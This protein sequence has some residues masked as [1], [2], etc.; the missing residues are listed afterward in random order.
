MTKQVP[1]NNSSQQI[2]ELQDQLRG[3]QIFGRYRGTYNYTA[4][5]AVGEILGKSESPT[6]FLRQWDSFAGDMR[7]LGNMM[8]VLKRDDKTEALTA[9]QQALIDPTYTFPGET[10][11]LDKTVPVTLVMFN[12]KATLSMLLWITQGHW[13]DLGKFMDDEWD[14][15]GESRRHLTV[16]LFENFP[17]LP[18]AIRA[19]CESINYMGWDLLYAYQVDVLR[20]VEIPKDFHSMYLAFGQ[21]ND[22]IELERSRYSAKT[23]T[24]APDT[25]EVNCVGHF[26]FW[27]EGDQAAVLSRFTRE[28][29]EKM[30]TWQFHVHPDLIR[31]KDPRYLTVGLHIEAMHEEF[32]HHYGSRASAG[33]SHG[34]GGII[35]P[36]DD[37]QK[38][39]N[40]S[41][42]TELVLRTVDGDW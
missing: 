16:P 40:A 21:Y 1:E 36:P 20:G 32:Q 30:A 38:H 17:S 13:M 2:A 24:V 23:T 22:H 11:P 39:W 4:M 9:F 18:R 7:V 6:E 3:H 10:I 8:A 37:Y 41:N 12:P 42:K 25:Q 29:Q 28:Q 34:F 27:V 14:V 35:N 5:N 19:R 15:Y 26:A 31:V 33:V